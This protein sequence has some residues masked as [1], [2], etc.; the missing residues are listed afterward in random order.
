M[1]LDC[2]EWYSGEEWRLAR[3]FFWMWIAVASFPC[4]LL[5]LAVIRVLESAPLSWS[6]WAGLTFG[7][8]PR[9]GGQHNNFDINDN[10][11]AS[12]QLWQSEAS[13]TITFTFDLLSLMMAA[14]KSVG[15]SIYVALLV[16]IKCLTLLVHK[17]WLAVWLIVLCLG[18]LVGLQD[19]EFHNEDE[20]N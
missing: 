15:L 7:R 19:S 8:A 4:W 10:A 9:S 16:A 12:L 11:A 6:P 1:C 20:T 13:I 18:S 3:K 14:A 5:A 2:C 17:P